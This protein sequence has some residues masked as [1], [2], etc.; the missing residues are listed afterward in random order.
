MAAIVATAAL[1]AVASAED[2][3][4]IMAKKVEDPF[5]GL[6]QTATAVA[7][8][9][10]KNVKDATAHGRSAGA[11]SRTIDAGSG[12]YRQLISAAQMTCLWPSDPAIKHA[13]QII[14]QHWMNWT[15]ETQAQAIESITL[16][17]NE[18]KFD[19]DQKK[20]CNELKI[21]DETEGEEKQ[22][23]RAERVLMGCG[24]SPGN[25]Q[26]IEH[27]TTDI[28][29]FAFLD[30]SETEPS[31]LVRLANILSSQRYIFNED[32]TYFDTWFSSYVIN[33]IDLRALS[34][35]GLQKSLSVAPYKDNTYAR[36]V[37][38][39]SEAM[40]RLAA[41]AIQKEVDAHAAKDPDWKNFLVTAPQAA[42]KGWT[43]QAVKYKDQLARS[44]AFE[45]KFWG[46]SKKAYAG[47]WKDLK[48]D[49]LSV[50]KDQKHGNEQELKESLNNPIVALL[51]TRLIGCASV[52]QDPMYAERLYRLEEDG[53]RAARG[54]RT[55]AYY[56]AVEAWSQIHA[57][58]EK[59][60]VSDQ[61]MRNMIHMDKGIVH[62]SFEQNSGRKGTIDGG[63][64]FVG[65]SG[66]GTIAS[67]KKRKEGLEINFVK[68]KQQFM[69]R[70]CTPTNRIIQWRTD[71]SPMYYENCHDTGL[72]FANTTPE[73]LAIPVDEW[74]EGIKV[75]QVMKF[76]AT[77]KYQ[78]PIR[79]GLP[80]A[81]YGDKNKKK[82]VMWQGFAMP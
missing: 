20:L 1:P 18:E 78:N 41:V 82:L 60:P 28:E 61:D 68:T 65:D 72:Y 57:D 15:G 35:A 44:N 31:E 56:G 2:F 29:L 14:L 52:D 75:G 51:F 11:L 43:D 79:L 30:M 70:S 38:L 4:E 5:M 77:P 63:G 16:R 24:L 21:D 73:S 55:A 48:K 76:D 36:A 69:G 19:A 46:P 80:T 32:R 59:F 74:Q 67:V 8:T 25:P 53:I 64:T 3:T 50:L 17:V 34:D 27:S 26:W 42:V 12:E 49:F 9:W 81:V 33:Y 45:H 66:E 54:A 10:C 7:P 40:G 37:G 22:F 6:V 13:V 23:N 58:R 39:E 71:G 62:R 47:C